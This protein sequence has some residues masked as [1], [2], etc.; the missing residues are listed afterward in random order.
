MFN[1]PSNEYV[2]C[3]VCEFGIAVLVSLPILKTFEPASILVQYGTVINHVVTV[4]EFT[5]F[6]TTVTL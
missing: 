1:Q 3:G 6:E 4:H 2:Y 5:L